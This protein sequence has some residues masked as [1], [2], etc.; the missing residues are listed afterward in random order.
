MRSSFLFLLLLFLCGC[1]PGDN[2]INGY[3][4]GEFVYVAPTTGGVLLERPFR[5][6]DSVDRG[7]RLFA[8]DT[9]GLASDIKGA[10]D[11]LRMKKSI[12]EDLKKCKRP[13]E[14]EVTRHQL[15][16]ARFEQ[17]FNKEQYI[18]YKDMIEKDATTQALY[19]KAVSDYET[20][21][22]KVLELEADLKVAY[23]PAREDEIAA[24]EAFAAAAVQKVAKLKNDLLRA[25]PTATG[26]AAVQEVYFRPG[27]YVPGGTPVICLL[28]PENLKIRF[29]V[30][31]SELPNIKAGAALTIHS[32]GFEAPIP[33]KISFI[34]TRAEFTPPV[35]YS[36]ESRGKLVFMIE[37]RPDAFHAA[38]RPGLPVNIE[39][40][41][42]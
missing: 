2:R 11:E 12:V 13:E 7:D 10:E 18:R 22:A 25:A 39:L 20:G 1:E 33:A 15:E 41:H 9:V 4:E 29:F 31:Q 16:Q 38:L 28:P 21:K 27:E 37:A 6:G 3:V 32:D 14:I 5:E 17:V 34:S 36:T 30:S 42:E 8:I 24:A 40:G 26:K 19:D 23:L 35:I